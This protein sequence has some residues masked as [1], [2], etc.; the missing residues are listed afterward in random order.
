[1]IHFIWLSDLDIFSFHPK[2]W[3][4]R[5]TAAA[6]FNQSPLKGFYENDAI[7]IC[8]DVKALYIIFSTLGLF[9]QTQLFTIND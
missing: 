4:I 3:S 1:M 7:F 5:V 2:D 6:N 9:N 8:V